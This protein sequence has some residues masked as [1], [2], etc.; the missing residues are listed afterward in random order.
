MFL[1]KYT[2]SDCDNLV[3]NYG[4]WIP[5]LGSQFLAVKEAWLSKDPTAAG[6]FRDDLQALIVR[7]L[8]AK[9]ELTSLRNRLEVSSALDYVLADNEY[10]D[11]VKAV[12]QGGEGS[13]PQEGDFQ[14]LTLRLQAYLNTIPNNAASV[15][16]TPVNQPDSDPDSAILK[17]GDKPIEAVGTVGK[18]L[19][20]FGGLFVVGYAINTAANLKKV[21]T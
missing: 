16:Y 11:L 17:N 1:G 8:A 4:T 14:D 10:Q 2:I 18:V 7:W 15:S 13:P 19:L 3:S 12:H 6:S 21:L 5:Q 9:A 20:V